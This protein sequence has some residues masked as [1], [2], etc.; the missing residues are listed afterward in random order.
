MQPQKFEATL[1]SDLPHLNW[2]IRE[3]FEGEATLYPFLSEE[4]EA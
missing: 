2:N 3:R 1:W 4:T